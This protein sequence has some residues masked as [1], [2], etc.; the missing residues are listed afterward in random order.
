MIL[1][2]R[3]E[4]FPNRAVAAREV[5]EVLRRDTEILINPTAMKLN[6]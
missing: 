3:I 2:V 4:V 6:L 5:E 1:D